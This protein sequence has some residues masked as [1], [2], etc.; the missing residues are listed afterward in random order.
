MGVKVR[1]H[2]KDGN[3]W[4]QVYDKRLPTGRAF[5]Y[6]G[7][8][9]RKAEGIARSI[10]KRLEA[11]DL[12]WA[13]KTLD[14]AETAK[15]RRS[16]TVER[17]VAEYLD[18]RERFQTL[19]PLTRKNY[20]RELRLHCYPQIGDKDVF[21]VRRSDVKHVFEKVLA[22]GLSKSVCRNI[23]APLR[24]CYE[25]L[26]EEQELAIENPA[27]RFGRLIGERID[28]KRRVKPLDTAHQAAFLDAVGDDRFAFLFMIAL[29][30]G[31]RLSEC[32]GLQWNDFDL[33]R[34]VLTVERQFREGHLLDR[35]KKNRQRAVPL[36]RRVCQ[37]YEL[38]RIRMETEANQRNRPLGPWVFVTRRWEPI[39]S[40]ST[41][42]RRH[43]RPVLLRAG[44]KRRVT[45]QNLRQTF[46]SDLA[47]EGF[48]IQAS[49]YAGHSSVKITGDYYSRANL[50]PGP[51]DTLHDRL[52]DT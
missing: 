47:N 6:V 45:M 28:K 10:A 3:A 2:K 34:R 39:R 8:D 21:D 14:R 41:F 51:V 37:E 20:E 43:L 11:G 50:D 46:I 29:G 7:K 5:I 12:G 32:F 19:D 18:E 16:L 27:T 25:W 49:E 23:L 35:T 52:R 17:A 1:D 30:A 13:T 4:I 15:Q 9:W 36:S 33:S 42:Y 31:L 22:N 44:L 48:L 38:H 40:K 24:G 26:R